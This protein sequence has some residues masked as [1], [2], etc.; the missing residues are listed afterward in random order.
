[1]ENASSAGKK[2]PGFGL[3]FAAGFAS[4][5]AQIIFLR[6]V[7]ALLPAN[8]LVLALYLT[9]YLLWAGLGAVIL[10]RVHHRR[11]F[12]LMGPSFFLALY[13][14][15]L[16]YWK[17][18]A[19]VGALP[20][21]WFYPAV[22]LLMAWFSSISGGFFSSLSRRFK[23]PAL[24][25]GADSLGSFASSLLLY[26]ILLPNFHSFT[27]AALSFLIFS[28]LLLLHGLKWEA[29]LTILLLLPLP[30]LEKPSWERLFKPLR[31][32]EVMESPY[33]KI[34]LTEYHG[35]KTIWVNSEK[36]YDFPPSPAEKLALLSLVPGGREVLLIG[37]GGRCL[38]YLRKVKG[39]EITYAEP[40][41][42]LASL[43]AVFFD[44][45][46]VKLLREDG[47]RAV[48]KAPR[49][50]DLLILDL[51]PPS[52]STAVRFYTEEFFR[53][54]A[55]RFRRVALSLPA[56]EYYSDVDSAV[57]SSMYSSLRG[58]FPHTVIV[59]G[60]S[61]FMM[62]STEAIKLTPGDYEDFL[63]RTGIEP[64]VYL[65][66]QMEFETGPL[67]MEKLKAALEKEIPPNRMRHPVTYLFSLVKWLRQYFPSFPLPRK[68]LFILLPLAL[69][70]P[71]VILR[72]E[73]L[74][75]SVSFAAFSLELLY[76]LLFQYRF[77]YVYLQ[78]SLFVG[79]MMAFLGLGSL[80][81]RKRGALLLLLAA[82]ALPL[83][84][85]GFSPW[86]FY[87]IFA[88]LGMGEGG[89]FGYLSRRI[90]SPARM[91]FWDLVGSSLAGLLLGL[92]YIPL[93][94]FNCLFA[95]IALLLVLS[96][97]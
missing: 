55:S 82:S 97:F 45:R 10:K 39:L 66:A 83:A 47:M 57:L 42:A 54:A 89:F 8:E 75:G 67:E 38:R 48:E 25:Y 30:F 2:S 65:P 1:M 14:T 15:R 6:E 56:G 17:S 20:S 81:F 63:R 12:L 43:A 79:L 62:G 64:E 90:K 71:G 44:L 19:S 28:L 36:L 18:R 32:K 35:Q 24:V 77:G 74:M 34:T 16:L 61:L 88:L 59:P 60:Q 23:N 94:G 69:L 33:G 96:F 29:I 93:F 92:A 7:L 40:N 9:F 51:P 76:L 68:N 21:P 46:G 3:S 53:K 52:S 73:Y 72:R 85:E 84:L 5:S 87:L 95:G 49:R 78:V 58:A 22:F 31:V 11:L 41:P 80:F 27:A 37:G 86:A 26:L 50:R 4:F 91:F 13:A 70:L